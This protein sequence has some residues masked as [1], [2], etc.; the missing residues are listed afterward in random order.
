MNIRLEHAYE[1]RP[2]FTVPLCDE[3]PNESVSFQ[4]V[5]FRDAYSLGED[6]EIEVEI[7]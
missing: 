5:N 4:E 1:E 3:H 6:T 2:E 7:A